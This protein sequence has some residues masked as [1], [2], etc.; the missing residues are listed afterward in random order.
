MQEEILE[1]YEKIKDQLSEE[2]FEAEMDAVRQSNDEIP[3]FD[4][5]DC[6]RMVLQN[7]GIENTMDKKEESSEELPFDV[8][9]DEG[10]SVEPSVETG[11]TMTEEI[12][13]QYNKVSDKISEEDF[14][15]RME[16][17]KNKNQDNPFMNE[18]AF[19]ESVVGEYVDEDA[20][21]A[22][23]DPDSDDTIDKLEK[24]TRG[25][26][27]CGRVISIS[28]P[29]SFKTRKGQSGE[30]CNVELKDNTGTI[31]TVFWT[32]NIK[33][34]KN[35]N[36]GDIIQIKDVDI[37]EGYSGLEANLRPRSIVTHLNEDPSRFP[38][39]KEEITQISDIQDNT[40]VNI[41]AIS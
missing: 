29:R 41:I 1:L 23:E 26:N 22:S 33:L 13:E 14:L 28:N 40:K 20:G 10:T 24:D 4:D 11:F 37:K 38:E 9:S 21:Y 5:L 32:Q 6:A 27:I 34:L 18:S 19:A 25:A 12:L 15:K 31:R 35:V 30:V 36:E 8:S 16:Y 2:E 17:Y 7:Y 39:Y 3:F